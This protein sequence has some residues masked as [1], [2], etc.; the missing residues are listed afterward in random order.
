[1]KPQEEEKDKEEHHVEDWTSYNSYNYK[2]GVEENHAG[3]Y[4]RKKQKKVTAPQDDYMPIRDDDQQSYGSPFSHELPDNLLTNEPAT[5]HN[6]LGFFGPPIDPEELIN[7]RSHPTPNYEIHEDVDEEKPNE[8]EHEY[9]EQG[10]HRGVNSE[11]G[12]LIQKDLKD[13][14]DKE[15]QQS[16]FSKGGYEDESYNKY[17]KH[18]YLGNYDKEMNAE[19]R[20]GKRK[21]AERRFFVTRMIIR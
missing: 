21:R 7:P 13:F 12:H 18:G 19:Q 11:T 14:Y 3:G 6:P 5:Q 10:Y 1:M 4:R 17:D 2:D 8:V 20:L 15:N 16:D 9:H